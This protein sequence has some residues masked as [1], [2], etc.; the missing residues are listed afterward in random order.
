MPGRSGSQSL[1][2]QLSI[3][4][5]QLP[6][7]KYDFLTC[8][9]LSDFADK[10]PQQHCVCF[11]AILEE[12][13]LVVR[14]MLQVTVEM[15]DTS[16]CKMAT[17]IIMRRKS[18]LFS[19]GFPQ[20]GQNTIED[21]PFNKSHLFNQKTSDSFHSLKDSRTSLQLLGIYTLAPK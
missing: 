4:D 20:E 9:K 12:C 19:S 17:G 3:L 2:S 10:L 8:S 21:L 6:G 5:F 7:T 11:E 14:M 13:K 1:L 16:S 18:W 15:A